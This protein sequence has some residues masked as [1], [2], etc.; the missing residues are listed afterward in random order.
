MVI[1]T[2]VDDILEKVLKRLGVELPAYDASID[3]TKEKFCE[4]EWTIPAETVK[5]VEKLYNE[6]VKAERKRKSEL[7]AATKAAAAAEN[8]STDDLDE[9]VVRKKVKSDMVK[10][11]TIKTEDA[12]EQNGESIK[13]EI[14]TEEEE[15]GSEANAQA[16]MEDDS[17]VATNGATA[18]K[19]V[20][21]ESKDSNEQSSHSEVAAEHANGTASTSSIADAEEG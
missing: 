8:A 3:P 14:K 15:G 4:L 16:D 6:K 21:T 10:N 1:S 7:A 20:D 13:A 9:V 18:E 12:S 5:A 17:G 19:V 11:E 2:Y